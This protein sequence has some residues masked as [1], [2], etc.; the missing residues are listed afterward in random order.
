MTVAFR[1]AG[2]TLAEGDRTIVAVLLHKDPE[3]TVAIPIVAAPQGDATDGDYSGI[4]TEVTFTAG[5]TRQEFTIWATDDAV[6]DDGESVLLSFGA[7][8]PT[9][10][11][12]G[13]VNQL[14][15]S[16]TDNDEP[17]QDA[18]PATAID[19]GD[20]TLLN[21]T[22]YPTYT[23][24]GENDQVDYFQFTLAKPRFVSL[25]IRQLDADASITL[26][27]QEGEVLKTKSKPDAEHV[28]IYST[29]LEGTYYVRV[30]ATEVGQEVGQNEYRLA[31]GVRD[32]DSDKVAELREKQESLNTQ[33]EVT[34]QPTTLK[35]R[36]GEDGQY[37]VVLGAQ[38]SSDVTVTTAVRGE[39][40]ITVDQASLTFT[41]DNWDV[42]QTV[43]VTA[44]QDRDDEDGASFVTHTVT[45]GDKT[46][47]A[48]TVDGVSVTV[49]DDD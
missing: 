3:R 24:D 48:L 15:L 20:I 45:S 4:P 40:A 25:G 46:Y 35:V 27:D 13:A 34:V 42:A 10:V 14:T 32:A 29:L 18:T 37:T 19:L 26:E 33:P 1:Q 11:S 38:P 43:T 30:E 41:E 6:D 17:D 49:S 5:N 28:M 16:I 9:R 7:T 22:R 8:L 23:I 39:S 47:D 44:A 12:A 21:K 36:E 2:Y 31:H